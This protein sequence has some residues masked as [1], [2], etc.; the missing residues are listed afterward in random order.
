MRKSPLFRPVP[1]DGRPKFRPI[2]IDDVTQCFTR[3]LTTEA[4]TGQT[5]DLG[6]ADELSLNEVL[7]EI[8]RCAGVRKPAVHVPMLLMMMGAAVM[9]TVLPNPPVT[10]G[11]LKMLKEG[12]TCDIGPMKQ[13]FGI[14]P[15]G[16]HGCG[17]EPARH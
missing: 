17:R 14:E 16:F 3:A 10:V 5:I 12:S 6:G 4:A 2:H 11:Q 9:Q 8:A 13:I 7:T 15:Q 1:G